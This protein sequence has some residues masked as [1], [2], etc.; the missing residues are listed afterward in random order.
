MCKLW[1]DYHQMSKF[2][3]LVYTGAINKEYTFT[4][5]PGSSS[6]QGFLLAPCPWQPLTLAFEPQM[7]RLVS[8]LSISDD[9]FTLPATPFHETFCRR[10]NLE[11][12]NYHNHQ[13]ISFVKDYN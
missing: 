8:S 7:P 2:W 9:N 4:E 6:R 12:E 5:V 10:D 1:T 11:V 13:S 3:N